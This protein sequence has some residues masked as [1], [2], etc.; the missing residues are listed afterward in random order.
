MRDGTAI[1][2]VDLSMLSIDQYNSYIENSINI[3]EYYPPIYVIYGRSLVLLIIPNTRGIPNL[4]R[5]W[6]SQ[7]VKYA[8]SSITTVPVENGLF[9]RVT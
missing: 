8:L 6:F 5:R 7:L 4:S 9:P 1:D 3:D 2:S